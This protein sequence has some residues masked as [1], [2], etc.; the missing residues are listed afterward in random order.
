MDKVAARTLQPWEGRTLHQM[1]RQ[2]SNAVNCRHARII[3]LSRGKV[4]NKEITRR[5]GCTPQWVRRIIHRFDDEGRQVDL[6][7]LARTTLGTKLARA[8]VM[9]QVAMR[10]LRHAHVNVTMKHYTDLRRTDDAAATSSFPSRPRPV[11]R[12]E[13][14]RGDS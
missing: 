3:L 5:V 10:A 1:K 11:Q 6:H 13:V 2:F 9:P 14:T 4:R 8:G 7:A 12:R